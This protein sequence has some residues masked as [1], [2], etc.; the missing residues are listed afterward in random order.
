M[1]QVQQPQVAESLFVLVSLC[2][3]IG[4]DSID[5][6]DFKMNPGEFLYIEDAA[7]G[8]L[9]EQLQEIFNNPAYDFAWYWNDNTVDYD[10]AIEVPN[11]NRSHMFAH[12]FYVDGSPISPYAQYMFMLARCLREKGFKHDGLW[13]AKANLYTP[14][15]G[16][17]R[18][19]YHHPHIDHYNDSNYDS[20]TY[21]L[22]DSDGDF[23]LFNQNQRDFAEAGI[24]RGEWGGLPSADDFT[25]MERIT[26][27]ANTAVVFDGWQYHS[28]NVPFENARRI[29]INFTG[30]HELE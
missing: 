9:L 6:V 25:I 10:N 4:Y 2:G 17:D 7:P 26:P 22:D 12:M 24:V 28:S 14:S 18:D 27:K 29:T 20:C 8:F 5:L 30:G 16:F 15:P 13:R 19:G 21:F 1:V 23:I 3:H 11:A